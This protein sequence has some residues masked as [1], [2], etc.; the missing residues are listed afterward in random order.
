MDRRSFI[1]LFGMVPAAVALSRIST[2]KEVDTVWE[3]IENLEATTTPVESDDLGD[4]WYDDWQ[5]S[6]VRK[7]GENARNK[8]DSIIIEVMKNG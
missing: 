2:A 6:L 3:P 1:K 8:L 4:Q 5:H 7:Y